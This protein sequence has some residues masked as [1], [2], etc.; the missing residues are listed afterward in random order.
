MLMC[1][2]M[3]S[4]GQ[5]GMHSSQ[6][7]QS[8]AITVW[9]N[10]RGTDDR[11]DRADLDTTRA[12]DARGLVDDGDTGRRIGWH[13][14]DVAFAEQLAECARGGGT[15]GRALIDLRRAEQQRFGIGP[16]AGITALAALGLWQQGIDALDFRCYRRPAGVPTRAPAV[17]R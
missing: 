3:Q 16:A 11:I 7:V 2:R 15:A 1:I 10:C 8:A 6:P 17:C 13:A 5:T 9:L 14:P 4:T 12:A